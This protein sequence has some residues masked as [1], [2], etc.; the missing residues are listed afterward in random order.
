M[1]AKGLVASKTDSSLG[2]AYLAVL[3]GAALP[4]TV[5]AACDSHCERLLRSNLRGMARLLRFVPCNPKRRALPWKCACT[6]ILRIAPVGVTTSQ[7]LVL[8][9][10]APIPEKLT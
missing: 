7:R 2:R 4:L 10:D 6:A 3:L 5:I 9:D 8:H 1:P